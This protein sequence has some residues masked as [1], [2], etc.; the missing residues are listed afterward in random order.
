MLSKNEN[1]DEFKIP[2]K[3]KELFSTDFKLVSETSS[4]KVFEAKNRDSN[5]IHMIRVLDNTKEVVKNHHDLAAT[6]FVQELLR[7]QHN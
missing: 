7:L 5:E 3:I 2:S 6:L 4:Y 1:S